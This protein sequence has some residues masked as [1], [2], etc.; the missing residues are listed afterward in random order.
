MHG[1]G[2]RIWQHILTSIPIL[3]A[4]GLHGVCEK[5]RRRR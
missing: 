1:V 5:K 4:G 3:Q 2:T